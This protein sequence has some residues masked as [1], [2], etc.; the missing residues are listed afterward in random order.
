M[1]TPR[2]RGLQDESIALSESSAA[3]GDTTIIAL[4]NKLDSAVK[5]MWFPLLQAPL[6][7][8]DASAIGFLIAEAG[9]TNPLDVDDGQDSVGGSSNEDFSNGDVAAN[10]A[11]VQ[12]A[13]SEEVDKVVLALGQL[14]TA[15]L[16]GAA[17][18]GGFYAWKALRE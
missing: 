17:I 1:S 9:G 13:V 3:L 18:V 8:A 12:G 14:G 11:V 2:E 10:A 4:T 7:K 5:G 15:L 6:L 16:V